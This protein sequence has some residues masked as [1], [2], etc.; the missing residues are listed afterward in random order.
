MDREGAAYL[1]HHPTAATNDKGRELELIYHFVHGKEIIN[2]KTFIPSRNP[3]VK[4]ITE[5]FPGAE[6]MERE[7]WETMGIEPIGHPNLRN[8][9]LDEKLSPKTPGRM[10]Q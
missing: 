5:H 8:L 9:V 2:I 7:L 1:S 3:K 4:S 10:K 6:L